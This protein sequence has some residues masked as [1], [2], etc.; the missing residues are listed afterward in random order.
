M[1]YAPAVFDYVSNYPVYLSSCMFSL[2]L[3]GL[4]I[5]PGVPMCLPCLVFIKDCYFE[6]ILISYL[7]L[8]ILQMLL[9]KATYN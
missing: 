3:S 8:L 5:T 9:S 2:C 6:F 1:N 4:L 7:H